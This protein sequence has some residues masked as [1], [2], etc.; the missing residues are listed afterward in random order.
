MNKRAAICYYLRKHHTGKAQAVS[1][2]M[3][4]RLFS[5][6]RRGIRH[7]I[8]V[9]RQRG[10]PICSGSTGYFYAE[11][12]RELDEMVRRLDAIIESLLKTKRILLQTSLQ[13]DEAVK[14]TVHVKLR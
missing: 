5:L 8:A 13:R 10:Y 4:G 3:L 6:S 9:L 1:G 12:Q 14:A 11:D 7:H 2:D